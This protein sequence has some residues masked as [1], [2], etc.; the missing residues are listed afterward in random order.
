MLGPTSRVPAAISL[1]GALLGLLFASY[2]T[3]DYAKHLDRGL[4]DVHCSFIPGAPATSEAEACRAAMYSPYSALFKESMWGGVPISLFAL[5]A[6]T[7][8]AGFA[9]YL[10]LAA[11]RAPRRSVIFFAILSL[12][13]LLVSLAML[14][15]S[16]TK[17]G[18][19]C[20]TCVGIYVSSF[21][22]AAGGIAGLLTLREGDARPGLG[23]LFPLAWLATLGLITLVPAVVYAA[24][25]PD[26]RPYLTKCGELKDTKM[27]A[28][29]PLE[30]RGSRAVQSAI[31]FEDPLCP[32]CKAFHD[33]LLGE[34]VMERLDVDLVMF[35]LDSECNWMLDRPLHP[36]A[37]IV[38][39]AVLCGGNQ[40]RQVLEWSFEEQAYLTRAGRAGPNVLRAAIKQRWGAEFLACVDSRK[41]DIL[42]N[43]HL[44]FASDN[45]VPVSTPQMYLDKRRVC[46]EDT[47][48][49]LRFTLAQLAPE[50]LK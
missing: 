28:G 19:L 35:P 23:M 14:T 46:D 5:G 21:L 42:L 39:K 8:F 37:C 6:F 33:R 17:I 15:L 4:H 11:D 47:D 9:L 24:S 2:S 27:K 1:V 43:Q 38:S 29:A 41:T 31:F 22:L 49:G 13:P 36:G 20:K 12:T 32:T 10:L 25:V 50:V 40:V 16:L 30:M 26:L 48:I 7:F 44:H 3:L 18:S 34:D 45:G